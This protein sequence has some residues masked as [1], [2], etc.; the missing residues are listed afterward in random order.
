[1]YITNNS[2]QYQFSGVKKNITNVL[3]NSEK[4][5][6]NLK[7]FTSWRINPAT[8]ET[9]NR[10]SGRS[11][12]S[13]LVSLFMTKERRILSCDAESI[14]GSTVVRSVNSDSRSSSCECWK[15]RDISCEQED[16]SSQIHSYH[17]KI[18]WFGRFRFTF[19]F[20]WNTTINYFKVNLYNW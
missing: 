5:F 11:D 12:A 2:T 20:S 13:A 14:G 10:S 7:V 18:L 1:M 8:S 3:S 6:T 19:G 4:R 16:H 17:G 15:Q 9:V